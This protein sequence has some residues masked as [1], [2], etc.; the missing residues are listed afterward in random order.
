M[1]E[2]RITPT[3][4]TVCGLPEDDVNASIWKLDIE[5]RGRGKWAVMHLGYCYPNDG[6]DER[7]Y[8]PIPSSRDEEFFALYR[9]DSIQEATV[10]AERVY[11]KLVINGLR[12]EN[13]VLIHHER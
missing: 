1:A 2:L 8:E 3:R 12:V 13:G 5:Y 11:P 9:F 6:S 10:C 4:F 7:T